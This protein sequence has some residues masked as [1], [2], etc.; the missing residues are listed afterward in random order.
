MN[1]P[2]D[3]SPVKEPAMLAEV[4]RMLDD[5]LLVADGSGTIMS[6][7]SAAVRV[8]GEGLSGKPLTDVIPSQ[9]ILDVVEGR[10]QERTLV[11]SPQSSVAMEFN[12]RTR[13]TDDGL[14]IVLLLDM[15]LQ[16]NL[17][18]VRRDFVANVSHE[19]R[20]PLTSLAGFI[21]T[22]LLNE[23]TDWP[24]QQRFLRIMEEEAGRMSRLID[25]LLSL[26]RV[27]VDE[28]I[29]PDQTVPLLEVVKSVMASLEPRAARRNMAIKLIDR[30]EGAARRLVMVGFADEINEVFHNLIE[31][32]TKYGFE[33]T[34]ITVEVDLVSADRVVISVSN[35]G[36]VIA[37]S[38]LSRLTERFYRVDKARSRQIGG[39]GLGLAIVK[40]IVNRHRGTMD[41]T[42]SEEGVTRFAVTLPVIAE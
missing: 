5:G 40:H 17:E 18:K 6:A 20:S 10:D 13:R 37:E 9:D 27:E 3:L 35:I 25:D 33:N 1:A 30:R 42:S 21:E 34:D 31:N 26:S 24:T 8:L 29:I 39:T 4:G 2:E 12:V 15:T 23:V 14:I 28:H 22:I 16:R 32:A 41:V 11:F 19:L 36:E 38:H 7:N